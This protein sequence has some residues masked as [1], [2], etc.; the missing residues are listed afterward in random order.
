MITIGI[1]TGG[2]CTDAVVYD[3]EAR[4]VLSYG[5]TL[6]TK[7][8]LKEGILKAL[9]AL[10]P[11]AVAK[12]SCISLSTTLATNA[13][14]EG[15]GGRAKL[16]FIG[17]K[18]A[19]VEKMAGEYGLPDVSEICFL[20]GDAARLARGSAGSAGSVTS[21]GSAG[22]VSF[23][24]SAGSVSSAGFDGS[25]GTPDWEGFRRH[26]ARDFGVYD[27]AAVVQI[28]PKYN[29]GAFERQAEAI[30]SEVLDIPCVRGYDLY[31]E[32][33]V[34]KRGATAL[35]NARLLPVMR[36]FFDSVDRSLTEMGLD[37][38][39]QVV[40]SDG[41]I[42][43]RDYALRR[44]VETLLCGPAASVIGALELCHEKE[45]LDAL[46]V[47]I[48]GTT[49]DV[50]LVQGGVP[51][52]S[53]SGINIG[54]WKTL[55]KG[56]TIDTFALGGDTAVAWGENGLFLDRRR[57]VPLCMAAAAYPQVT[58][59]LEELAASFGVYS[60]PANQFFMLA[61]M[62]EQL[63]KYTESEQRLI[64]A[65]ADGPLIY[66]DAAKAV[67]ISPYI[68]KMGRLEDEGVVLRCGVTPTDV[69]H[70]TGDYVQY[71]VRAS[72][73]GVE[74][75]RRVTKGSFDDVCGTIYQLAKLRLYQNLV[76]I[77]MKYETG[78]ELP[79]EDEQALERLTERIFRGACGAYWDEGSDARGRSTADIRPGIGAAAG[80]VGIG[81]PDCD[82]GSDAR[83]RSAAGIRP[84]S[85][86]AA[87]N[88]FRFV[89]PDFAAKVNLIGIGAPSGIFVK[90]VAG[91]LHGKAL[92][93]EFAM[94]ANAIGA[95]AGS[96]N[97][98]CVVRIQPCTAPGAPG[99]F[100]VTGGDLPQYFDYY[101]DALKAAR[102]LAEE[103]AC[104]RARE[105]GARG[106][107]RTEVQ[108]IEDH[109]DV[110]GQEN[111]LFLEARVEA[112]TTGL[113]S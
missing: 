56:I 90:D 59:R 30:I 20:E 8:D 60:Y 26:V 69:M 55:V 76:R 22:S 101:A 45:A 108:V 50:A 35:L 29:D 106:R 7:Q 27:S 28:N 13:C 53:Q 1:D 86:A 42:M 113:E 25:A 70:I 37:L 100:I 39:I 9:K 74:Y 99:K 80:N 94:V 58:E 78:Q 15:K 41:S 54:G 61:A 36:R 98:Q 38:P 67:G 51:V 34:Q 16:V 72:R 91:L 85:G 68:L 40:K 48:G 43:S 87:G 31:Q 112:R 82:E 18:P 2:T 32:I 105:Q 24:G 52:S 97:S 81:S 44:P 96:V 95:A 111:R 75:L 73:L 102:S 79:K 89:A 71:D 14:V 57:A 6:T 109:Y 3:T 83:G 104:R 93:P 17:V 92:V 110:A 10:A 21:A 33:N 103:R 11:E 12:A 4:Q 46:I 63:E 47:D 88:G 49:S 66:E 84:G 107:L 19:V 77:L 23:A 5:K 64:K 65:L 62:P